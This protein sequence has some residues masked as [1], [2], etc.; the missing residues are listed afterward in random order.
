MTGQSFS[1]LVEF[2]ALLAEAAGPDTAAKAAAEER[3]GQLT[4]PPGALGTLEDLAIWFASWQG[5]GRPSLENPQVIVFAGNHGVTARGVSAFPAEVTEQMVLNFQHGGA[6]INQLSKA[7]GAKMDVHALSLDRPT[8][9]FTQGPAMSEDEVVAALLTGWNAVD[10]SAD[11]LVTGEMGIGNT[12]SAAAIAHALFGGEA[13][14]WAGRGTG[15][16]DAGLALKT[17]VVTEGLL[18]NPGAKGD[19][20]EALRCLG[21]RELAA[22]AGA[23]ARARVESI[24]VILDGFICTAA[25]AC[26]AQA[27]AGA[28]DHT[29]AGHVSAEAAHAR[30]LQELGKEP[31]LSMGMRLGEGSGAALAIGILKGAVACHSGMATFAE[32][33][34]SDG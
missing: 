8:A 10:P 15:V 6:A 28:L 24:P 4:K 25:A 18:A 12:T 2:Q 27:Q 20:I 1:T 29:V 26:L 3:N 11:L 32:A 21:G 31:L 23:I 16:D 14:D 34:V 7:F 22:M 9:D 17:Q 33:G 5:N 30:V 13:A 19:G